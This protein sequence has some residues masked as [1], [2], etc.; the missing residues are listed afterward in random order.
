MIETTASP[1][2]ERPEIIQNSQVLDA[3]TRQALEE[4]LPDLDTIFAAIANK[5][6]EKGRNLFKTI[7]D[8]EM[9]IEGSVDAKNLGIILISLS[10]MITTVR[11]SFSGHET[12]HAHTC[13]SLIE[14]IEAI[15]QA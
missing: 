7:S 4:I 9:I 14:R 3:T 8:L 10:T 15:Q 5:N 12:T 6:F 13:R 1:E 2:Q 11:I